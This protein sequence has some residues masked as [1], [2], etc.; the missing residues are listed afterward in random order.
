MAGPWPRQLSGSGRCW[1]SW[2]DGIRLKLWWC[3]RCTS[4]Q[5]INFE[6]TCGEW[7]ILKTAPQAQALVYWWVPS[8][9]S[10][11]PATDWY[12]ENWRDRSC[13]QNETHVFIYW[14]LS[15]VLTCSGILLPGFP[16]PLLVPPTYSSLLV[17]LSQFTFSS[18]AL[19]F[20]LDN[21]LCR[22]CLLTVLPLPWSVACGFQNLYYMETAH[23]LSVTVLHCISCV[24]CVG[25]LLFLNHTRKFITV[26]IFLY[27]FL[28]IALLHVS[29]SN[30]KVRGHH[31]YLRSI[32][33]VE[34]IY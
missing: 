26:H 32:V 10:F 12:L 33:I 23:S 19:C 13:V 17:Y 4:V 16:F 31:R 22:I 7:I 8:S 1:G 24:R 14:W 6:W 28:N 27:Y 11:F 25:L 20:Y 18:P 30:S 29:L 9:S 21:T 34:A 15:L 2:E 3:C 5:C